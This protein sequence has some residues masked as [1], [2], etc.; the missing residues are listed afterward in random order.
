MRALARTVAAAL[1]LFACAGSLSAQSSVEKSLP[2]DGHIGLNGSLIELNWFDATPKRVGSVTIKRRLYG[3]TGA[4]SWKIFARDLG[5][6]MRFSDDS[7]QPGVAYEYQILRTGRDIVDVGY[8]LGG[9]ALPATETRGT[10]YL[11]IDQTIAEAIRPRLER[12][13]RDLTGDGWQVRTHM[14]PRSGENTLETAAA[15]RQ[16]LHEHQQGDP[17]GQHSVILIGHVPVLKSGKSNPDGHDPVPQ[18]TDLFYAELDSQ[19][20]LTPERKLADNRVPGDFIETHIGRIDFKGVS[21]GEADKEIYLLRAYFDKNH[22]WRNGLLGDLRE[23][24]AQSGHLAIEHDGL[25]N[26]LGPSSVTPGGHHDVGEEKPWLWG[27]DFGDW[28]GEVYAEK[29]A[30]KAVF[31]INFGSGKQQF[32]HR[33]NPMTAL[34]AQPWYPLAVGW[35]GRPS[36]RLHH[37]ALGG[38]IGEAHMR[39][40][41]NG[42]AAAPYRETM[43]YF[44]TGGY[45]WR[46]PVWVNLLG[47]PTLRAFPLRPPSNVKA[48]TTD[49]G[50]ELTWDAPEDPDVLG[51]KVYRATRANAAFT[52]ISGSAPISEPAFT[53]SA[54]EDGALYMVRSYGLKRVYA[55]SFYTL[56]QGAFVLASAAPRP[57]SAPEMILSAPSK[58]PVPLPE[59]FQQASPGRILAVIE[60]PAIGT[61]NH[62]DNRWVYTPPA[63]FTGD[64]PL[65]YSASNGL[66]TEEGQLVL[67]I[68]P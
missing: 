43:D 5:P 29:Y 55:G 8:W 40:V 45:L 23:G 57:F 47:D 60:P 65:R 61:L 31:A 17:F 41:N 14:A 2:V 52:A 24:Y 32:P 49:R 19:W 36:W 30:N 51:Y 44:P 9:T 62:R 37:M 3:Q 26:V 48:E 66:Q 59:L 1:M 68:E 56:S 28:N 11:V 38:T 25:K 33:S 22:H 27:V 42:R 13:A 18:A 64:V 58:Q 15:I 34:L 7:V 53:D 35:G 54:G 50:V 21:G 12:F 63:G 20:T 10:A 16:W 6:V 46:N 67:Q 4:D 39:T